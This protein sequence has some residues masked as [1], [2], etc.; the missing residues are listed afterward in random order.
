[1]SDERD[2]D[3]FI[4]Q[5]E[6][7][8]DD[9][10]EDSVEAELSDLFGEDEEEDYDELNFDPDLVEISKYQQEQTDSEVDDWRWKDT[11]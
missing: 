2:Q 6:D 9:E 11:T 10:L 5:D 1:M 8:F 3:N 4:P 7:L